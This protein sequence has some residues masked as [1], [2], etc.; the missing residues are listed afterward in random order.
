MPGPVAMGV[1][2]VGPSLGCASVFTC[3]VLSLP[4][5]A[6]LFCCRCCQVRGPGA[7]L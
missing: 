6:F 4:L 7:F 5:T 1:C 2:E 3:C